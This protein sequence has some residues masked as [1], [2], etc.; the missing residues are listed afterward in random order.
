MMSVAFCRPVPVAAILDFSDCLLCAFRW[1]PLVVLGRARQPSERTGPMSVC[2]H[3]CGGGLRTRKVRCTRKISKSGGAESTLIL[4]DAQCPSPKPRDREPCGLADCPVQ[5][6]IEPWAPCSTSCGPGEQRRL[7]FCEQRSAT[8]KLRHFNPPTECQSLDKPPTVQLCNLGSCPAPS[9][10]TFESTNKN[11][12]QVGSHRRL[13]LRIG[14]KATLFEGT[15]VKVKC[16]APNFERTRIVWTKDGRTLKPNDHIKISKFGAL[17]IFKANAADAGLYTCVAGNT[18]GNVTLLFK[19][20]TD[21]SQPKSNEVEEDDDAEEVNQLKSSDESEQP[22]AVAPAQNAVQVQAAQPNSAALKDEDRAANGRALLQRL[23]DHLL[24]KGE[25]RLY[26]ALNKVDS[27]DVVRV[28]WALGDW[29]ICSTACDQ[30][31]GTQQR[32]VQCKVGAE[33]LGKAF[34]ALG[35]SVV[36]VDVHELS[37]LLA[38]A[39][40]LSPLVEPDE[41]G[42]ALEQV[43]QI[44]RLVHDRDALAQRQ[45]RE[46]VPQS[47]HP[48]HRQQRQHH[49]DRQKQRRYQYDDRDR[50]LLVATL[51]THPS[52]QSTTGVV[53]K[54][55]PHV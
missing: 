36:L 19:S 9:P 27:S 48:E 38:V 13:T 16:P 54:T 18:Q 52:Q 1:R 47:Q 2:S 25:T 33:G 30:S 49:S 21:A 34:V 24:Q 39:D 43:E 12:E 10:A 23:R 22:S 3:T 5:W 40:D 20:R 51:L 53:W 37:L 15:S 26:E 41:A 46:G 17:R 44:E 55:E 4:P 35:V 14:G 6:R 29:T 32:R 8:G 45:H 7:V 28:E 42:E 31:G 50:H 11:F